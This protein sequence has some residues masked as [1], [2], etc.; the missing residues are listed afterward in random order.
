MNNSLKHGKNFMAI[1]N[2]YEAGLHKHW[3]LQLFLSS[4]KELSIEVNSQVI[5]SSAIVI[6]VDTYHAVESSEEPSFTMLID[7]TSELGLI[8]REKLL[9]QAYFVFDQ[10]K[11]DFMQQAFN[12]A[13]KLKK[14]EDYLSFAQGMILFL[15]SGLTKRLDER[16]VQVLNLL[17][18]CEHQDETH[19]IKYFSNKINLSESRLAHLFKDETSIPLKSYIVLHKLQKTYESIINGEN[20]TK[21]AINAGFDSPSHFA[22]TNKLMTG[23]TATNIVK[24]SEFLKVL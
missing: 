3:L 6:N 15:T 1:L 2:Q 8:L 11:T 16:V 18:E 5:L 9:N 20:I 19:Q 13:L 23:M 4:Q 22:Y 12:N 21:A 24:D 7:P 10:E 14:Y 17:E